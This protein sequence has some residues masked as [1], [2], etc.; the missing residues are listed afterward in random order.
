MSIPVNVLATWRMSRV[1]FQTPYNVPG[2]VRGHGEVLLEEPEKPSDGAEIMRTNVQPFGEAEPDKKVY[3]TM[4][5]A[6]V[7]RFI[8]DV[9]QETVEVEGKQVIFSEVMDALK[10]FMEKWRVE[11]AG[12]PVAF[13]PIG[14]VAP[15]PLTPMPEPPPEVIPVAT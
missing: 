9:M 14:R 11:D 12:K 3:G 2:T 8:G 13:T 6:Q 7:S 4:P 5:G 15:M 10:A 1:E